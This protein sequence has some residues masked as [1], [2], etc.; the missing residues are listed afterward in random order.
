MLNIQTSSVLH[1]VSCHI[2]ILA[3]DRTPNV[4]ISFDP[5]RERSVV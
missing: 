3:R 4:N 2:L 5:V 1:V